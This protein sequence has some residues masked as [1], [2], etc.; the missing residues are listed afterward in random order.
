MDVP[1]S[2]NDLPKPDNSNHLPENSGADHGP[3]PLC[4]NPFGP[5]TIPVC[6]NPFGPSSPQT[7]FLPPLI[8]VG[9]SALKEEK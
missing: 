9:E 3:I 2:N 7:G 1:K 6:P 4:P 8:P 5:S